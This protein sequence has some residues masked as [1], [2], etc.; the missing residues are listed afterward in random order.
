MT[1]AEQARRRL[2]RRTI[3]FVDEIH[4]F[5]KAQQDAFLPRVEAGDIVLVGATTENPSFEVNAAL[6]SRSKVFV[7]QAARRGRHRRASSARAARTTSAAWAR[8]GVEADARG[9]GGHRAARQ[10]RRARRRW[11]C[12]NWRPGLA[13]APR[14]GL[15]RR[16][17]V[18]DCGGAAR[19]PRAALRQG[20]RGALQP[21]LGAAQ[22]DA[23]QRPRRGRLLARA[24]ARGGRGPD[25]RRAAADPLRVRGRR[26]R[27]SAGARRWRSPPRTRRT[28]SGMPE[29]NTA[30]AQAA[31][32]LATAPKSNAVYAAYLQRRRGRHARAGRA[33]AAAPPQRADAADEGPRVRQGL[34]VRPRRARRRRRHGLPAGSRCEGTKYYEPTERG[35]EKEI[36]RRL[37]A[38][39][40]KKRAI[41]DGKA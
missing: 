34:R 7:L 27:R 1:E 3:L 2:G 28:C 32:Y 29:A 18:A 39:D 24:H 23:Q 12:W 22:V 41:R 9:A 17:E 30:L 35:F 8:C 20:R 11:A 37:D 14:E 38:W 10:R 6:L 5:N 40:A 31:L 26:Q 25:V 33:R 21:H 15:R 36:K 13:A 16:L 4:R 19:A